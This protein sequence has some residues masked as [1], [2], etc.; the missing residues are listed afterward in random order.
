MH[1]FASHQERVEHLTPVLRAALGVV[2]AWAR[3]GGVRWQL[4][5]E[6]ATAR[7]F[8]HC[9]SMG[10]SAWTPPLGWDPSGPQEQTVFA[11]PPPPMPPPPPPPP[12][13]ER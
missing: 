7:V 9:A 13:G 5:R 3:A 1:R 6:A 12:P 11:P 8:Y 10:Q 2:P 4:H